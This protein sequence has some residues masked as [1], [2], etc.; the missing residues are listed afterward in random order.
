MSGHSI[1][2]ISTDELE[3]V[4]QSN[5]AL[6]IATTL[7]ILAD[8]GVVEYFSTHTHVS[9]AIGR[10]QLFRK[11]SPEYVRAFCKELH[12]V[13]ADLQNW[14]KTTLD[15][16]P[17]DMVAMIYAGVVNQ[18]EVDLARLQKL[19]M[20]A[21]VGWKEWA[22][23]VDYLLLGYCMAKIMRASTTRFYNHH[24]AFVAKKRLDQIISLVGY[25]L[26]LHIG[27][28]A[29]LASGQ[30]TL[31]SGLVT[32]FGRRSD[33]NYILFQTTEEM[34]QGTIPGQVGKVLQDPYQ[35]AKDLNVFNTQ[36]L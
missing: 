30:R 16:M 27:E 22:I 11:K 19:S 29:L 10:D 25:K 3:R 20:F 34:L 17:D 13:P 15:A 6:L 32:K 26:N 23:A 21:V 14:F 1:A 8:K 24:V 33:S 36:S 31:L 12:L 7:P 4:S 9:H 5:A 2:N 28:V 18:N 35:R